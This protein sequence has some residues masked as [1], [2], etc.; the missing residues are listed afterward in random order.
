MS[1]ELRD[2]ITVE[3]EKGNRKDYAVE[4]LFDIEDESFALLKSEDETIVMKVEEDEDD[5]YL[6][7]ISD[8]SKSEAILNAYE[9]AVE[10]APA[11]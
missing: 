5:Q 2:Y 3:D 11:E 10:N 7:G 8:P 9:I 6:V 4:A 1:D